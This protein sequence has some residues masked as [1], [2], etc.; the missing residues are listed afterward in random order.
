M[1]EELT[2]SKCGKTKPAKDFNTQWVCNRCHA[3]YE[4]NRNDKT[5]P[6]ADRNGLPWTEEEDR[7]I[8][9]NY[10]A[11]SDTQLSAHL[12]RTMEAVRHRRLDTLCLPKTEKPPLK[13]DDVAKFTFRERHD[14]GAISV[15]EDPR[16]DG[17]RLGVW[18][19]EGVPEELIEQAFF[20]SGYGHDLY[21]AWLINRVRI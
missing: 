9:E 2:C 20:D 7:Y 3:D 6:Q 13:P 14:I 11:Q 19:P 18:C 21:I 4:V 12:R 5:R 16:D 15:V 10:R 1:S 8:R 17:L